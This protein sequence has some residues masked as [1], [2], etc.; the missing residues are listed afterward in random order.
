ML[1]AARLAWQAVGFAQSAIAHPSAHLMFVA[2]AT[3][4]SA[5]VILNILG[6]AY[7]ASGHSGGSG[8]AKRSSRKPAHR[9]LAMLKQ[10]G[11][12]GAGQECFRNLK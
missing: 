9:G 4:L 11:A 6:K 2:C 7:L 10:R 3:G 5:L 8:A 12:A 1:C